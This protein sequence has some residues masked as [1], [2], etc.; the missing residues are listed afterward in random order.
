MGF[1]FSPA[2]VEML[3]RYCDHTQGVPDDDLLWKLTAAVVRMDRT[4]AGAFLFICIFD[5]FLF[6]SKLIFS[7]SFFLSSFFLLFFF[8]HS[9]H[10]PQGVTQ[11][12]VKNW[13]NERELNKTPTPTNIPPPL[14]PP[15]EMEKENKS[16]EKGKEKEQEFRP[17]TNGHHHSHS[18]PTPTFVHTPPRDRREQKATIQLPP[19]EVR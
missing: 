13:F 18:L 16:P 8:S 1:E 3:E 15:K 6:C 17:N 9:S 11:E 19:K 2:Q 7:F 10:P 4:N 5:L 14:F 12:E